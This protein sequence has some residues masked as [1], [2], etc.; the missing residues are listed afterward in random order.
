MIARQ[1]GVYSAATVEEWSSILN[2]AAKWKFESIRT[3]AI[4]RLAGLASPID[5]IVLGRK[6]NIL[7]WLGD[8]YQAVCQRQ[9]SLTLEEASQLSLADVVTI[10]SLRQDIRSSG[11]IR[12]PMDVSPHR[13]S[14]AFG[15]DDSQKKVHTSLDTHGEAKQC[16][17]ESLKPVGRS[18]QPSISPTPVASADYLDWGEEAVSGKDSGD[19]EKLGDGWGLE[20]R[21]M[22]GSSVMEDSNEKEDDDDWCPGP[23]RGKKKYGRI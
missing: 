23:N 12:L 17:E 22:G 18:R 15:L 2:L 7:D 9:D 13:I 11:K 16:Y 10:S 6:H 20:Y 21:I 19:Q 4:E 8:A 1:I 3:L 14:E 5:K